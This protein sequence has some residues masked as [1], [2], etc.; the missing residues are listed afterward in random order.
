MVDAFQHGDTWLEYEQG[1]LHE[2][3]SDLL[4]DVDVIM[5]RLKGEFPYVAGAI[6]RY[7]TKDGKIR[8]RSLTPKRSTFRD[9]YTSRERCAQELIRDCKET[10]KHIS[11]RIA[12]LAREAG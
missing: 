4:Q 2:E 5:P 6:Q 8:W 12:R 1:C 11:W 9:G 7:L 10:K 3:R